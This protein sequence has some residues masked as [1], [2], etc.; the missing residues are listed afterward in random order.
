VFPSSLLKK[1]ENV[2]RIKMPKLR[3]RGYGGVL[4]DCIKLE[5]E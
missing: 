3:R 1:G 2:I 4:W 5:I